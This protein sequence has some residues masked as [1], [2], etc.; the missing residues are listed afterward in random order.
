[1]N[2][3]CTDACHELY[4]G[5]C[6]TCNPEGYQELLGKAPKPA[7]P[8]TQTPPKRRLRSSGEGYSDTY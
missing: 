1:M 5:N 2:E 6:P 8:T 4:P 3:P 7:Q